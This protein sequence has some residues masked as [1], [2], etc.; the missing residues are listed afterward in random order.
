MDDELVPTLD[1]IRNTWPATVGLLRAARA[2]GI[3]RSHAYALVRRNEF[4]ARTLAV[5]GVIRVVTSSI[6]K[7]LT[8]DDG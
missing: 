7:A 2:F 5:G 6:I 8:E 4:P 1:E 3:S